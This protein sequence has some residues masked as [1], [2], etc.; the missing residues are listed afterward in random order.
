[1]TDISQ[2]FGGNKKCINC[3]TVFEITTEDILFYKKIDVPP[4]THCPTCRRQ[5]RLAL[6]NENCLHNRTCDLC[7]EKIISVFPNGTTYTVYCNKCWWGDSWNTMEY[8]RDF[9]FQKPFFEQF[10]EMEKAIPHI[11]LFQEGDNQNCKYINY[12]LGNKSCYLALCA[13]CENTYYTYGGIKSKS[14]MDCTKIVG[15]ELCYECVDCDNCYDLLFSKDCKNCSD[16]YFLEDCIGCSNC[17]FSVGLHNQKFVF[18]NEQLS[19][20]DYQKRIDDLKFTNE[21][22][23][24]YREALERVSTKIPKKYTHGSA[25]ENVTGDY[26][27]NCKSLKDCYDCLDNIENAAYSDFCGINSHD[28]YDCVY[29]GV[30]STLCY[31]VNGAVGFNN[32]KFLYYGRN[33]QDCEYCQCCYNSHH[34]FGCFGLNHKS[35]C[36]LNK[37]Y[38]KTQYEELYPRIIE[39]IKNTDEYGEFFPISISPMPYSETVAYEYYP[40]P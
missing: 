17:S 33:N 25:N 23:K 21:S 4:P 18:K 8:G 5:R 20:K 13:Y 1:M 10:S 15:C 40:N 2:A 3:E 22:I 27:D 31:E 7:K 39:H 14:C 12:G 35:Y 26:I 6:R 19:E 36:I 11:A 28:F 16:S 32:C 24:D 30:G 34:L 38:S 37:A 29:F 9:D